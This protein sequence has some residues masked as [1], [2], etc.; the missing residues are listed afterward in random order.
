MADGFFVRMTKEQQSDMQAAIKATLGENEELNA[1]NIKRLLRMAYGLS[2][3][4][5][6]GNPQWKENKKS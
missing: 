5:K 4:G 3:D 6:A 2:E 1:A